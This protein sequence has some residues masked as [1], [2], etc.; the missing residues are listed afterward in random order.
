M[1]TSLINFVVAERGKPANLSMKIAIDLSS[2][3][4][5]MRRGRLMTVTLENQ[6]GDTQV[7]VIQSVQV[8]TVGGGG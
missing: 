8:T 4:S 3:G 6:E 7:E 5:E 2:K 1:D